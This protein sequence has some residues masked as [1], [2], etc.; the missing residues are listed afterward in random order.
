MG[1]LFTIGHSQH[2]TSY[3]IEMLK[4]HKIN[5]VLDVRST[6]YSKYAEQFN[7]ENIEKTLRMDQIKY[8]FMG[9]YFGARPSEAELYHAEGYLDFEKVR[10]SERF[11]IGFQ[12]VMLG[13]QQEN[14]IA[15]MCTEKDPFNCHR[16]IMVSRA[17]DL[18]GIEIN[19]ILEDGNLQS[20]SVLND[21]LLDKYFPERNQMSFFDYLNN[22]DSVDHLVEAYR[23]RNKE[24]GYRM[25]DR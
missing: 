5:F 7:R 14:N 12:N 19:H 9:N 4:Q 13:L 20:Q 2:D 22:A 23:L 6:P 17:F 10:V 24:I 3:F 8:S 25:T 1:N 18:A 15:F 21:R 11:M 16:A